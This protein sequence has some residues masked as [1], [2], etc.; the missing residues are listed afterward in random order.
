MARYPPDRT[1]QGGG[2]D[3]ANSRD[4]A[5]VV[6]LDPDE[7]IAAVCGRVDSA[8]TYAVI[9][10]APRG[11]RALED[12]LGMRRL[13]RHAEETGRLVAIATHSRQLAARAR[14]MRIPVARSPEH[15]DW[16]S[17]GRVSLWLFGR[18]LRI[19][20]LGRY[21]QL[22]VILAA[23]LA[24]VGAVFT[25]LPSARVVAYPPSEPFEIVVSVTAR[26]DAAAIDFATMVVPAR[27]VTA[28][29]TIT[30]AVKTTGTVSVPVVQANAVLSLINP[31]SKQVVLPKGAVLLAGTG[32]AAVPFNLGERT[33]LTPGQTVIQ[34]AT[35]AR[36]GTAGNVAA[37]TITAWLDPGLKAITVTN[38]APAS[39]G[40]NADRPAVSTG[41]VAS[42][43]VLAQELAKSRDVTRAILVTRPRDAVFVDTAQVTVE[44]GSFSSAP[45]TEAE[46]LLVDVKVKVT[47]LAVAGDTLRA[48]LD[49]AITEGAAGHGT[50]IPDSIRAAETGAPFVD[51]ASGDIRTEL[52]ITAQLARNVTTSAVEN[53]VTGKTR[54]GAKS[55][56]ASRYA[57]EDATVTTSPGWAPWVP[58]FAF[59]VDVD[60]RSRPTPASTATAA[61][62]SPPAPTP[63]R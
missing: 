49:R 27:E 3:S 50:I 63:R 1:P 61:A 5:S 39:G 30:L 9:L 37:N 12:E 44:T 26:K 59:R 24:V 47:A 13:L 16:R 56:L 8:S 28:E 19:P 42:V 2:S 52:R 60:L 53:A 34:G 4:L 57:I 21:V 41:D 51:A 10:H 55:A 14:Q 31:T 48:V 54:G 45:G 29:R 6:R 7:D 32:A 33:V 62:P 11:N 58:R 25:L 40:G 15:V 18:S 20:Q 38:P 23:A 22:V 46:T 17:G 43:R 35:A 36:G